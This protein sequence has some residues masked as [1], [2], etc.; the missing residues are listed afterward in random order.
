MDWD[1]VAA[2]A[3]GQQGFAGMPSHATRGCLASCCAAAL[4]IEP[5]QQ[6][7]H[8]LKLAVALYTSL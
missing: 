5:A 4:L 3:D 2:C 7:R 1:T 8:G 6:D